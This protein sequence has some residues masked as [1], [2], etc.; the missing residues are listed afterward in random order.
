MTDSV[1]RLM[2][3]VEAVDK[4]CPIA[5]HDL[6]VN[7]RNRQKA[8]DTHHYGPANPDQPG[9]YWKSAAK[10]WGIDEKTAKTMTCSNCAAFNISDKM[11]KCINDGMGKQAF[12]PDLT[13]Q[14]ADLG[15][16]TLLHFKCAGSR[17]C[18]L[19][20]TGGPIIK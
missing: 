4:G 17:S 2:N 19:W 5:T 16:C 7:V 14:A 20:L 8:I 10:S 13:R 12:Q 6:T 9:D 18:E 3:L 15:Y 1:R 11:Y